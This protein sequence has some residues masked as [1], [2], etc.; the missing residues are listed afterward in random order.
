MKNHLWSFYPALSSFSLT[1]ILEG[2]CHGAHFVD[3]ETEAQDAES[4][5]QGGSVEAEVQAYLIP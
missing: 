4:L 2:G 1:V 3:R 5:V